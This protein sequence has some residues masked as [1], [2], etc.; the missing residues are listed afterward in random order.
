LDS[1][2]DHFPENPGDDPFLDE[3]IQGVFAHQ[4]EIDQLIERYSEHW[5]LERMASIDRTLLRMAIFELLY[6]SDI[7]PKVTL[8]EAVDLGKEY[9]TEDTGPF[10]NG[11]LDR[12]LNE[13]GH[14][15]NHQDRNKP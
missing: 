8:N 15:A 7:P 11:L 5:R 13:L 9:G 10:L 1:F 14:K 2:R 4:Q 6:C 3:L 12:I